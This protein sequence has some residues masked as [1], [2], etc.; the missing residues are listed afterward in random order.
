L[1]AR[2]IRT[3]AGTS[4]NDEDALIPVIAAS[5]PTMVMSRNLGSARNHRAACRS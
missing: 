2:D 4:G 5:T 3:F 1:S